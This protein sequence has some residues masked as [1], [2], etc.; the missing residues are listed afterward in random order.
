MI[1]LCLF[2]SR[3]FE[4]NNRIFFFAMAEDPVTRLLQ[5]ANFA[6]GQ[7]RDIIK[8]G[9]RP[10]RRRGVKKASAANHM[11]SYCIRQEG[12]TWDQ[13]YPEVSCGNVDSKS[14]PQEEVVSVSTW[15]GRKRVKHIQN[16]F[17]EGNTQ[18]NSLEYS[19][20]N[21]DPINLTVQEEWPNYTD[22]F[23]WYMGTVD[24]NVELYN[25]TSTL[26][27]TPD[28]GSERI[29][30]QHYSDVDVFYEPCN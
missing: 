22:R 4:R 17:L 2:S 18:E 7:I 10:V 20:N 28:T 26:N 12:N 23:L 29:P 8:L 21:Q 14:V 25:Y 11:H 9:K 24:E 16:H 15:Q 27:E 1:D 19:L 3:K 13:E 30:F 5:F 6:T